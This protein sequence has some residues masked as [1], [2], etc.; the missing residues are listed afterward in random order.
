MRL[1][2]FLSFLL[3]TQHVR[4]AR[5]ISVPLEV[6]PLYYASCGPCCMLACDISNPSP[7]AQTGSVQAFAEPGNPALTTQ[8]APFVATPVAADGFNFPSPATPPTGRKGRHYCWAYGTST[9]ACSLNQGCTQTYLPNSLLVT[10]NENGGYLI[11]HC[12]FFF[13]A[14]AGASFEFAMNGSKPF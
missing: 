5:S 9:S 12:S 14:G 7:V 1:S 6:N 2:I 4:A 13:N 3:V 11:G 8:N 10:I